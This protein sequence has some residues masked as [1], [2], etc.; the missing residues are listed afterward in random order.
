MFLVALVEVTQSLRGRWRGPSH[1]VLIGAVVATGVVFI[2]IKT[3]PVG[4]GVYEAGLG[5]LQW[6][7]ATL[8]AALAGRALPDLQP[9]TSTRDITDLVALPALFVAYLIGRSR[10]RRPS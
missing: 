3:T 2:L 8:D 6:P 4:E 7:F 5:L 10:V 1:R 9:V